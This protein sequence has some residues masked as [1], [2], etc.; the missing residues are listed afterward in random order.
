MNTNWTPYQKNF[1]TNYSTTAI[2]TTITRKTK[3]HLLYDGVVVVVWCL[4]FWVFTK[5]L[6]NVRNTIKK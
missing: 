1:N 2:E 4:A 5:G 3:P 6:L